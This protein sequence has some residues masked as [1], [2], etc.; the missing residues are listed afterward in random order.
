MLGGSPARAT[1]KTGEINCTASTILGPIAIRNPSTSHVVG[2]YWAAK[3]SAVTITIKAGT[4]LLPRTSGPGTIGS[5]QDLVNKY[6][7][8]GSASTTVTTGAIP[9]LVY[10]YDPDTGDNGGVPNP[11][12]M[13]GVATYVHALD[14]VLGPFPAP[15]VVVSPPL[16][17]VGT[18]GTFDVVVTLDP[19]VGTLPT[20][21]TPGNPG[22]MIFAPD[23]P[24]SVSNT[25]TAD[26]AIELIATSTT[27]TANVI[28]PIAT[29]A[30]TSCGQST[31]AEHTVHVQTDGAARVAGEPVVACDPTNGTAGLL[32]DS[33]GWWSKD[34]NAATAEDY[35]GNALASATYDGCTAPDQQ[36]ADWV[37]SKNGI[38]A[39]S[40]LQIAKAAIQIKAKHFGNCTQVDIID[41]FGRHHNADNPQSYEMGGTIKAT[42][43]TSAD[44]AIPGLKPSQGT[45]AARV[46]I[47]QN[48]TTAQPLT[49]VEATGVITKGLGAGGAVTFIGELDTTAPNV[50]GV[51][52]CNTAGYTA[53]AVGKQLGN[54]PSLPMK[55][56]DDAVLEIAAP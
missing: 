2:P 43:K 39:P 19:G 53:P 21:S 28:A 14:G 47:D 50:L 22:A 15:T 54:T 26:G 52:A 8:V 9:G 3:S 27:L 55:T 13:N 41:S 36:L 51:I 11:V 24:L 33:K 38:S 35:A 23:I 37:L 44:A 5:Y 29:A 18:P 17:L 48:V 4:T 56:G 46:V 25:G 31:V 7:V 1:V 12:P 10:M 45:V 42:Y 20:G 34:T 30:T 6:Q 32:K 49:Y 40:A 16:P